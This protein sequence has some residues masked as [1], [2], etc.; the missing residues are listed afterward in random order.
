MNSARRKASRRGWK[1]HRRRIAEEI[2]A[3]VRSRIQSLIRDKQKEISLFRK[4]Q[5]ELE[6]EIA[7][8]KGQISMM[9][10][11][12]ADAGCAK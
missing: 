5:Q 8:A 7:Y 2:I 1:T 11:A 9:N 3:T 6:N 12:D 10:E 4:R